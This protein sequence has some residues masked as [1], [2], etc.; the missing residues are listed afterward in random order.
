[1]GVKNPSTPP[2]PTSESESFTRQQSE[3]SAQAQSEDTSPCEPED[4]NTH[5]YGPNDP[6]PEVDG[7]VEPMNPED[8]AAFDHEM[9]IETGGYPEGQVP[10]EPPPPPPG[11]QAAYEAELRR[12]REAAA[13]DGVPVLP[14][15]LAGTFRKPTI[16][17]P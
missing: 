15:P 13:R 14:N 12:V 5:D 6:D 17:S 10:D 7:Y 1:M 2:H 4:N 9:M 8:Q 3:Q 11:A 16:R